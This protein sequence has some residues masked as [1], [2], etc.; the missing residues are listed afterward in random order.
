MP[1]NGHEGHDMGQ[2]EGVVAH[3][4]HKIDSEHPGYE[5]QDVNVGG[6]ITFV[7]GLCGFLAIFFVFCFL[8]GKAINT[9]NLKTYT[10]DYGKPNQWT[11]SLSETGQTPRGQKI[12]SLASNAEMEQRQLSDVANAFPSPRVQTDDGAQDTAELHAR[13]DLLLNYYSTSKD[14]PPG[15]I[16]I[17]I[18]KAMEL[19][20]ER[21]LPKA[22]ATEAAATK[23]MFG[24]SVPTV[25][26]PLTTGFARTGFELQSIEARKE[27]TEVEA[28][29]K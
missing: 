29:P 25:T 3:E 28:E 2:P 22:P 16:R 19:V 8:M 10:A 1:T 27:R 13:E 20:V 15:T 9:A 17:P 11:K 26:A 21:G 14:L 4:A 24:D 18:E 23:P 12:E 5:I 6:I 7:A